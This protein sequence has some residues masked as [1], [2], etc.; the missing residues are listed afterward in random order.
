M[1][2]NGGMEKE[3]DRVAAGEGGSSNNETRPQNF[4][5]YRG[6]AGSRRPIVKQEA[7]G[8]KR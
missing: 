2:E 8:V 4:T 1:G 6:G 5:S 3:S 7:H